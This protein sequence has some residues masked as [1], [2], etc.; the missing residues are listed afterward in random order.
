MSYTRQIYVNTSFY[1][2]NNC[3][4]CENETNFESLFTDNP[5]IITYK[6][7]ITYIE[8]ALDNDDDEDNSDQDNRTY[9]LQVNDS[10][11]N[12]SLKIIV[13]NIDINNPND[14]WVTLTTENDDCFLLCNK[15]YTQYTFLYLGDDLH[16]LWNKSLLCWSVLKYNGL[17][18]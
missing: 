4:P 6:K 17:F 15:K 2:K 9:K 14:S 5:E 7:Q 1:S 13:N 18:K 12:G 8:P 10:I 16:L 3:L 11:P